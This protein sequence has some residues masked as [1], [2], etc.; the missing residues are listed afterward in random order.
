MAAYFVTGA[1]GFV[2]SHLLQALS[3]QGHTVWCLARTAPAPTSASDSVHWIRAD[4]SQRSDYRRILEQVDYVIHLA[5]TVVARRKEI[6]YSANV[7][8]T[9][10][11]ITACREAGYSLK[12]FVHISSIAAMG[13]NLHG[14]PL[15]SSDACAPISEYGR[16]K[17]AGE[18]VVL[19][20]AEWLPVTVLRP[21]FIY[22][23]GDLRGAKYFQS[24]LSGD[25][26]AW[27][28]SIRSVSLCHV[29]DVIR[30]CI[31]AAKAERAVGRIL[32]I[33]DPHPYTWEEIIDTI[34]EALRER[35]PLFCGLLDGRL[36]ALRERLQ[37]S[38]RNFSGI[39]RPHFWG[40][41]TSQTEELLGRCTC[42]SLREG[43]GE[44]IG[45][46]VDH[47]QLA[48]LRAAS[49]SEYPQEARL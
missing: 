17:L 13:P 48:A 2:G 24:F 31:E 37:T 38:A 39:M 4:L 11:L 47:L 1:T 15:R 21:S 27:T 6:F 46:Y 32:L 44:A 23:R 14:E 40:C 10:S 49:Q 18:R 42:L 12:R 41:D 16:S 7:A 30:C 5:G 19:Q 9:E 28:G 25:V 3:E 22:G 34:H 33:S 43:A 36:H 8:A 26:S 29:A 45:W 20:A 35:H